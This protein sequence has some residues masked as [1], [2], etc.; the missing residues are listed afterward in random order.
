ME[1]EFTIKSTEIK[2]PFS[3]RCTLESDQRSKEIWEWNGERCERSDRIDKKPCRIIITQVGNI[4][5]PEI[6]VYIL[7]PEKITENTIDIAKNYIIS[8]FGLSDDL[9]DFYSKFRKDKGLSQAIKRFYGLR[10]M[11]DFNPFET[12]ITGICSQNTSIKQWN[13][14][15]RN[16]INNFG[17]VF[18]IERKK[19][20]L[21][22]KPV[23][24][25]IDEEK[26]KKCGLGYRARYVKIA[27][28]FV[29]SGKL[30]LKKIARLNNEEARKKLMSLKGVGEKVADYVLL[31]GLGR[32][33]TLPVDVWIRRILKRY[34]SVEIGEDKISPSSIRNFAQQRFGKYTG[35][36]QVYLFYYAR[37][38]KE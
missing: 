33:D 25:A 12:L 37:I 20:K 27:A 26:L 16:L 10:L 1:K 4:R 9:E 28:E 14:M 2:G 5:E 29:N 8:S 17:E 15:I 36:A 22:P 7:S 38:S 23:D 13:L 35:L 30:D 19:Y 21:F 18:E 3:L 32:S 11:R 34:Y 24:L 6:K 31:Y